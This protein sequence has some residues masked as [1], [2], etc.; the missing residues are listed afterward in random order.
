MERPLILVTNDDGIES[1]GLWAVVEAVQ[2]LGE[3]LVVAPNQQ[4]S[5]AARSMPH[6]LTGEYKQVKR[7]VDGHTISGYAIDASPALA[8]EH[9]VLEFASRR[10]DLVISGINFGANVSVDVTISGTVGAALEGSAFGIPALAVSLEM[11]PTYYLTGDAHADYTAAKAYTQRFA[12]TLLRRSM[13]YGVDVLN[14]NI[15][16]SA[17]LQTPW[18]LTH[19]SQYRYFTPLR[20][21]RAG[22]RGRP[23]Y[24]IIS[25]PEQTEP[26]S[27]LHVLMVEQLVS[28]TPLS[29]N[30]TA[31]VGDYLINESLTGELMAYQTLRA[32]DFGVRT[33]TLKAAVPITGDD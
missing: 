13:P 4:W 14:L 11:D 20:P 5:G 19:L 30:L 17:Q 3:I 27:D 21:D 25:D 7:Q 18:R 32:P 16:A 26:D 2:A 1:E 9:G 22:G 28:V 23:G 8:V 6:T 10:P 29:L 12:R 33:S 24:R 15:P 31:N